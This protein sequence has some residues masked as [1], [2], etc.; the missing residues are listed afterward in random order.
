MKQWNERSTEIAYL[1]NPAFCGRLLYKT[2]SKYNQEAKRPFPFPLVYLVLPLLLHRRTREAISSRSKLLLWIQ[3]N[4]SLLISYADRAKQLV[5]ITNEA[6]EWLLQC[7]CVRFT[8]SAEL[9]ISPT[10]PSLSKTKF[11]DDEVKDC[12]NKSEHIAKWFV[13][14]GKTETIFIALGVRP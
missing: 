8:A 3:N 9:E 2:I 13:N 11:T 5:P 14:A 7:N 1:L 6:I 10:T 12:L 4:E